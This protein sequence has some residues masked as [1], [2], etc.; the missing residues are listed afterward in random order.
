MDSYIDLVRTDS[1]PDEIDLDATREALLAEPPLSRSDTS[2]WSKIRDETEVE[3]LLHNLM[4]KDV[5]QPSDSDSPSD[6]KIREILEVFQSLPPRVQ[7][8]K[9]LNLGPLRPILDEFAADSDRDKFFS[10]YGEMLLEGVELEHLVEDPDGMITL[11]DVGTHILIRNDQVNKDTRFS[12][13]MIP[14]GTDEFGTSRSERARSLYRAWNQ[15]KS[16]RAQYEEYLFKKGKIG[17]KKNK[18]N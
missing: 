1:D 16:G 14:Y 12:V 7:L 3:I 4:M 15:H 17:L 6:K 2:I 8:Q 18:L 9:L 11:D 13:K 10:R 5:S